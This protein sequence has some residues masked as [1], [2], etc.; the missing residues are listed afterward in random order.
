MRDTGGEEYKLQSTKMG[1]LFQYIMCTCSAPL[2]LPASIKHHM[3]SMLSSFY[4]NV[5]TGWPS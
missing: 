4:R 3:M 1:D 5:P 2:P